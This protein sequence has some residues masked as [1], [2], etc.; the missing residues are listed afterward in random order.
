ME[1]HT[2]T[3]IPNPSPATKASLL[4]ERIA[5]FQREHAKLTELDNEV[6]TLRAQR[7][8]LQAS[9]P[10][11]KTRREELRQGR[12]N[13]LIG[14][15]VCLE[16]AREYRELGELL[17]DAEEAVALSE[18]QERRLAMPL[19]DA[20]MATSSA[21]SMVAGCYESYLDYRVAPAILKPLKTQLGELA[22]LAHAKVCILGQEGALRWAQ[23]ELNQALKEAMNGHRVALPDDKPAAREVLATQTR[24]RA[25]DLLRLCDTPGKRCALKHEMNQP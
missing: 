23:A 12:I 22:A 9:I 2:L 21:L 11:A 3:A 8:T 20:H 17:E 24:P 19:Y 18:K 1:Q 4:D 6:Q 14:G 10:P 16:A 15:N 13:Q 7:R 5:L 25:F